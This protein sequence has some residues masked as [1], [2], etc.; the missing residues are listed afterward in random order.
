MAEQYIIDLGNKDYHDNYDGILWNNEG[1]IKEK[2]E[3][4]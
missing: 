1:P 3:T 2:Q 4:K